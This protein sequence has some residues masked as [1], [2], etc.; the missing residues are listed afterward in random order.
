MYVILGLGILFLLFLLVKNVQLNK[1]AKTAKTNKGLLSEDEPIL[2]ADEWLEQAEKYIQQ[3]DPRRAVR[4]LYLGSLMLL[5]EHDVIIFRRYET[6]W[7][8]LYRAENSGFT[9]RGK[10]LRDV[11]QLFDRVWYG[12][13]PEANEAVD[14]LKNYYGALKER[15]KEEK[16]A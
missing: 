7:E 3:G 15:L 4:A 13:S 5:D 14:V 12:H 10:T 16:K 9:E 1:K 8:H 11:T 6:N 2:D